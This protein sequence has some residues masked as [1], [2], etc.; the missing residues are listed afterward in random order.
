MIDHSASMTTNSLRVPLSR[1]FHPPRD[2]GLAEALGSFRR[3]DTWRLARYLKLGDPL[4]G[5]AFRLNGAT[6]LH[7]SDVGYFNRVYDFGLENVDNLGAIEGHYRETCKVPRQ[8]GITLVGREGFDLDTVGDAL[9]AQ[10]FEATVPTARLGL[11]LL[12]ETVRASTFESVVRNG[13]HGKSAESGSEKLASLEFRQPVPHE[14]DTV[15]DLYLNGFQAP[16]QNH[17]A[18][19]RNMIQLFGQPELETWCAFDRETP[20]ALGMLFITPP[21]GVLVAGVTSPAFQKQGVHEALIQ[22]RIAHAK[23]IG[24]S[25]LYAWADADGQS[26]RN[27]REQG[28]EL[29]RIDRAWTQRTSS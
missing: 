4:R 14:Y 8:L 29:L 2:F 7:F 23:A 5:G 6:L 26:C 22:L 11:D 16:P 17:S 1:A 9:R 20:V 3:Y 19:K 10:G 27:L 21:V 12:S 25:Q 28:F 13:L 18:A 24:C 15:L